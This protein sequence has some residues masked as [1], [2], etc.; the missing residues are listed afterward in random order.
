MRDFQVEIKREEE[1]YAKLDL[2]YNRRKQ[3]IAEKIIR[4]KKLH[5]ESR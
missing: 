4:L 5:A 1:K 2:W 3:K